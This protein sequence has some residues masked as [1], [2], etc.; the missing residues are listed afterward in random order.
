MSCI[1]RGGL[2]SPGRA[3]AWGW[4]DGLTEGP[5]K[6]DACGSAFYA[7]MVA[8][9][10]DFRERVLSMEALSSEEFAELLA[11]E[12]L[13]P[14]GRPS[15]FYLVTLDFPTAN[16]AR[17]DGSESSWR[18]LNLAGDACK[19]VFQLGRPETW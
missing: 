15:E 1:C 5:W 16:I 3:W 19:K 8:W 12:D 2:D 18:M 7:R 13:L 11:E 10:T 17:I 9:A 14:A 4:Y 6:C